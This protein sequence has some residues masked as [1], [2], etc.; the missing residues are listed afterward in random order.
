MP[1]FAVGVGSPPPSAGDKTLKTNIAPGGDRT[2]FKVCNVSFG[3]RGGGDPAPFAEVVGVG[4][5]PPGAEGDTL[6][7]LQRAGAPPF[8]KF[9]KVPFPA[10]QGAWDEM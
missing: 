1:N 9:A 6:K 4:S 10:Q 5:P 8:S 3:G 2:I 7:T